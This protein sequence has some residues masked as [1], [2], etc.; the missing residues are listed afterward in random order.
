MCPMLW[1]AVSLSLQESVSKTLR[2]IREVSHGLEHVVRRGC[3]M[4][5]DSMVNEDS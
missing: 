2:E 3:H 1:R 5:G 4:L